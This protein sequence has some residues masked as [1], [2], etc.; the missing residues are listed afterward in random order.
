LKSGRWEVI[1][2]DEFDPEFD[3]FSEDVQNE[4]LAVARAVEMLGPRQTGLMSELWIIQ[5]IPT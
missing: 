3:A 5:S 4:L 2:H 1:F